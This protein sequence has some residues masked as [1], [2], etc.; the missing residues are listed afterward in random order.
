M[1]LNVETAF[2]VAVLIAVLILAGYLE[3][4]YARGRLMRRR[5]TRMEASTFK[6][7]AYNS[8]VTSKAIMRNLK[9]RG[10][11]VRR[12]EQMIMQSDA[13][14]EMGNF[15]SAKLLA[16]DAKKALFETRSKGLQTEQKPVLVKTVKQKP[17]VV[18]REREE[19]GQPEEKEPTKTQAKL[20]RNYAEASFTMKSV[21]IELSRLKVN[22]QG[23]SGAEQ[24]LQDARM[25]FDSSDYDT[26]LRTAVRASRSLSGK[27]ETASGIQS[28][29]PQEKATGQEGV[30]GTCGSELVEGDSFCR[31][32]GSKIAHAC[33]SCGQ[34]LQKGDTFC[35]KCGSK[36]TP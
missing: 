3:W 1:A 16:D 29:P 28:I 26:A 15:A 7:D 19:T 35:G 30:C 13:E 34:E 8:S 24:L 11:D 21:E 12:A 25:A 14:L 9:S 31:K 4:S 33:P 6:D 2:L 36:V 17:R 27:G 10:Y 20:P 23:N 5:K 18:Q 22:G 32:C